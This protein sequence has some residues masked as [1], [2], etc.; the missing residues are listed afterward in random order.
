MRK[1]DIALDFAREL[2]VQE[3]ERNEVLSYGYASE[4]NTW[5]I[6][7]K[8]IGSLSGLS[9]K[10]AD[11]K[12]V[13][14]YNG[15]G[16]ITT[17]EKNIDAIAKEPM[18]VYVEKPKQLYF[19]LQEGRAASCVNELQIGGREEEVLK[20][21]GVL[22]GIVDSGIDIFHPSFRNEDGSTRIRFLWDQ[23]ASGED[24]FGRQVIGY[25]EGVEY[26]Q[27]DINR[28]LREEEEGNLGAILSL[29][30]VSGHGTAVAGIAAG[31]GRGLLGNR[32]R[33]IASE[34]EL[35]VVK[36]GRR[37]EEFFG[38]TEVMEGMDYIIR[39]ALELQMPVAVNISFGTNEGAHDGKTLFEEYISSL[40]GIGANTIV[41]ATGNEG[42]SRHHKR[43]ELLPE[44]MGSTR[45]SEVQFAVGTGE[46]NFYLQ[47]WKD[48]V[49]EMEII[50]ENPQ[51]EQ[52]LLPMAEGEVARKRM[53]KTEVLAYFGGPTPFSVKQQLY[54][55][56]DTG[57]DFVDSGIW[58]LLFSK[59]RIRNGRVDLWL[60]TIEVIGLSTGF[61][62]ASPYTTLTIPSTAR[63]IISVGAYDITR[64]SYASFSG[65]GMTADGR[66]APD[67]VA[68]GVNV[69]TAAPGGRYQAQ[70]GTSFAAPFVTGAAALLMEWGIIQG[71]DSYL[72]GE[73]VKAYLRA[74]ARP[75]RGES[76][77][78]NDRVGFGK[79]CVAES[80][81]RG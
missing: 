33:G 2:S 63:D 57:E 55:Q 31:N 5:Q 25:G 54:I 7:V 20:G 45:M 1:T 68:P 75:L 71:N 37:R 56:W 36:L 43:L 23:S 13:E 34:S 30:S 44:D 62:E 78:P 40:K 59:R 27:E 24:T 28:I 47:I 64:D 81:P 73:K 76:E 48:Y 35:I 74:G 10:Y 66:Q 26:T 3:R 51:G 8:Y 9:E 12:A 60:P 32:Y 80:L 53:G 4:K 22:V 79:L 29:D 42:D 77:Y 58:R 50:L 65:R 16:I 21:R 52:F 15:Y 72:Y 38:T 11:T 17:T 46:T 18:I 6:I 70:T 19:N 39:K 49:D 69:V 41:I 14:L 67:I 61:L